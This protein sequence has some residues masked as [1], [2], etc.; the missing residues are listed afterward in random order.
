MKDDCLLTSKSSDSLNY[1]HALWS[2]S[3][4]G[5]QLG[6]LWHGSMTALNETVL[7][8]TLHTLV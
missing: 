1:Q 3:K 7:R 8:E 6:S 5:C 2:L 4:V